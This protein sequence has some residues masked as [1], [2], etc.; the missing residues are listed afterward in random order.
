[1]NKN[2]LIKI[3]EDWNFWKKD[4]KAGL[5]RSSYL[6]VLEG[7]LPSEQIKVIIGARRSEDY[8]GEESFSG[9]MIRY[10]PLRKWL[11][12]LGARQ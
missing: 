1:M 2:E 7:R 5:I 6:D 10:I 3:L 9:K 12:G 11:L 8:E 4:L